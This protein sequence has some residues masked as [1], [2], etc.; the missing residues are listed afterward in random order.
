MTRRAIAQFQTHFIDVL[1]PIAEHL[2][3]GFHFIIE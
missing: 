1:I 2:S 3:C